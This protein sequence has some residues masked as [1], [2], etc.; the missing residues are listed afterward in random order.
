MEIKGFRIK[1]LKKLLGV[2]IPEQIQDVSE[3]AFTYVAGYTLG[4]SSFLETSHLS[5]EIRE[6]SKQIDGESIFIGG[7]PFFQLL[8][9]FIKTPL[10][11]AWRL[12]TEK[13]ESTNGKVHL[14]KASKNTSAT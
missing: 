4:D 2:E 1:R 6:L 14:R 13:K 5:K 12:L 9:K 7:A 11:G 10:F 8:R 3:K